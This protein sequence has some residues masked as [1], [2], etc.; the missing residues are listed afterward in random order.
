MKGKK[1]KEQREAA[2][3]LEKG[4][5]LVKAPSVVAQDQPLTLPKDKVKVTQ[6]QAGENQAIEE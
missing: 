6:A 1:A 2:V 4:T 3:E 5:H